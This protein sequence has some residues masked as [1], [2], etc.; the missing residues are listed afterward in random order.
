MTPTVFRAKCHRLMDEV[1]ET[2]RAI[3]IAK[4]GKPVARLV[5]CRSKPRNLFGTDRDRIRILGDITA[6]IDIESDA[7]VDTNLLLDPRSS[8]LA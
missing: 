6:P 1:A 4:R 7:E 8:R 3:V 5:P 2:G